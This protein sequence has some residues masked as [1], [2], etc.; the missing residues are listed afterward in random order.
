[1]YWFITFPNEPNNTLNDELIDFKAIWSIVRGKTS[2]QLPQMARIYK[3]MLRYSRRKA[4][5][6]LRR[7]PTV[8]WAPEEGYRLD[9]LYFDILPCELGNRRVRHSIAW[10]KIDDLHRVS[11]FPKTTG[12]HKNCKRL[13]PG[14]E[15]TLFY[16][17]EAGC[18][19]GIWTNNSDDRATTDFQK[20]N[21]SD[22]N[23]SRTNSLLRENLNMGYTWKHEAHPHQV[24]WVKKI[25]PEFLQ[26]DVRIWIL[27][28]THYEIRQNEKKLGLVVIMEYK[29]YLTLWPEVGV[30][31]H[32]FTRAVSELITM[33]AL[34][35]IQ[36][37][38]TNSL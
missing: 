27:S 32:I 25:F 29:V 3:M 37:I 11:F 38:Y 19:T 16:D 10:W 6:F 17:S 28:N 36:L 14:C 33:A 2:S 15:F 4:S 9:P 31:Q 21:I 5:R 12:D 8:Y 34:K 22:K 35:N 13:Q 30:E 23:K 1:M 24:D 20:I 7:F 18:N 26:K